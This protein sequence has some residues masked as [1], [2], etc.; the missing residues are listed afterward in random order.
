MNKKY[1]I[2]G[3][4]FVLLIFGFFFFSKKNGQKNPTIEVKRKNISEL[5]KVE[6]KIEANEKADLTFSVVGR[7]T[8]L[9]VKK[10]DKVKQGQIL[11]SIDAT[12]VVAE[13]DTAMQDFLI[14]RWNFDQQK[15]DNKTETINERR[16][17]DIKQFSLNK[18]VKNFEIYN[19]SLT[20][21]Y[22]YAPFA[23]TITNVDI[24]VGNYTSST[25][26]SIVLQDLENLKL[27]VNIPES[28]VTKVKVGLPALMTLDAF[29]GKKFS[30]KISSIDESETVLNNITYYQAEIVPPEN[31]DFRSGMAVDVNI[32]TNKK[33]N[34][35]VI[36]FYAISDVDGDHAKVNIIKDNKIIEKDVIIG[37]ET[38]DGLIEVVSGLNEGDKLVIADFKR[39]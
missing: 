11:A 8:Y 39:I 6:G 17:V 13:K 16:A 32:E 31:P 4:F 2:L 25:K 15:D 29:P 21:T 9:P 20:T 1:I 34:A 23:G 35:L 10:G 33:I 5:V 18:A 27:V 37:L 30:G 19:H 28:Q 26:T 14:A 36:P 24:K 22:I 7:V 12:S 38:E 3:V